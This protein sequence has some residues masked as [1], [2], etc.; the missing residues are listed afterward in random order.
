[1]AQTRGEQNYQFK[2]FTYHSTRGG[3][4]LSIV[5]VDL[6][7]GTSTSYEKSN[8]LG[9]GHYGKVFLF[10]PQNPSL[11]PIAIKEFIPVTTTSSNQLTLI[12]SCTNAINS[13]LRETKFTNH[14]D[15]FAMSTRTYEIIDFQQKDHC[16]TLKNYPH[17][18]MLMEFLQ[19]KL[20]AAVEFDSQKRY[21][22]IY[23]QILSELKKIHKKQIVHEDLRADNIF[24]CQDKYN[25][26][27]SVRIFDPS[28]SKYF[29]EGISLKPPLRI[30]Y[31]PE[32]FQQHSIPAHPSQDMYMVGSLFRPI[33]PIGFTPLAKKWVSDLNDCMMHE[34]PLERPSLEEASEIIVDLQVIDNFIVYFTLQCNSFEENFSIVD[35]IDKWCYA[36]RAIHELQTSHYS[37]E[38]LIERAQFFRD[39]LQ[40]NKWH[41]Q[42]GVNRLKED[43]LSNN[44]NSIINLIHE[45]KNSDNRL[46]LLHHLQSDDSSYL[47]K[48]ISNTDQF[49]HLRQEL[50]I[51]DQAKFFC[52]F[53]FNYFESFNR[54]IFDFNNKNEIDE[55]MTLLNTTN[56]EKMKEQLVKSII[57]NMKGIGQFFKA[58][59]PLHKSDY[60]ESFDLFI[61]LSIQIFSDENRSNSLSKKASPQPKSKKFSL[62]WKRKNHNLKK[63]KE[64]HILNSKP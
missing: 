49:N 20:F 29:G 45:L 14:F 7:D 19:D 58:L 39:Q 44:L 50:P 54:L 22:D 43:Y 17:A 63:K 51:S 23:F 10:K 12:D 36:K 60:Q 13:C 6:R 59:E 4:S 61:K 26:E 3:R 18:Y 31:A 38:L 33:K 11:P 56:D 8:L 27:Y 48:I 25:N 57:Y 53:N 41:T 30:E 16:V 52:L 21:L 40:K 24:I 62:L 47:T 32:L 34:N 1:M 35:N 15:I 5:V 9:S 46:L 55:L 28:L 42:Y 2:R 64:N 37:L